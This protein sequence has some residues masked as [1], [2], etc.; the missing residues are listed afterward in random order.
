MTIVTYAELLDA[1]PRPAP[2]A[3]DAVRVCFLIDDLARAGTESQLL[4]LIRHLDR[5]RVRPYLCLLQGGG[6]L[7]R[8]LEPADCPVLRLGV[9]SLSAP[10]TLPRLACLVRFLRA[11]RI[12]VVQTYF[13]DSTY[14]GVLAARLAGVRR[15]VRTRNNLGYW[16]TRTDRWLGWLCNRFTDA[17]VA[18]CEACRQA[19]IR[20][21]TAPPASVVV[22]PNGVDFARFEPVPPPRLHEPYCVG[23]VANL[24]PV[25]AID[26]LVDAAAA[27]PGVTF[28]VAGEG[29][30]RPALERQIRELGLE[31]RFLLPGAVA[32]TPGF[33]AGLDVAVLCSHSEGMSNAL[34]EYLAAGRPVVATAVGANVELVRDGVDGLLVPPGDSAALAA[35][36]RRLL[37]DPALAARFGA[38]AREKAARHHSLES[39]ARR[40]EE[41]YRGLVP[42]QPLAA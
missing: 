1:P 40:F 3:P 34:L 12:D 17:T 30:A 37:A 21:E 27:V 5:A 41:F 8:A 19:V 15:V 26:C 10:A 39:R 33:L 36:I 31:G 38:A 4:A 11:A 6:A 24:R 23:A 32:D 7:S 29:E 9:R 18:N 13:A 14:L 28:R 16:M 2:A 42:A 35:A 25:K 22:L 20:D